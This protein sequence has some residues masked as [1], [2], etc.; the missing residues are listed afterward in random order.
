MVSTPERS[1]VPDNVSHADLL[2]LLNDPNSA[3]PDVNEILTK[4]LATLSPDKQREI[5]KGI[6]FKAEETQLEFPRHD[7]I[8]ADEKLPGFT[9]VKDNSEAESQTPST[10][11][12]PEKSNGTSPTYELNEHGYIPR[13][14]GHFVN[15]CTPLAK[16]LVEQGNLANNPKLRNE[17]RD[18]MYGFQSDIPAKQVKKHL[19]NRIN[20]MRDASPETLSKVFLRLR[21]LANNY[22]IQPVEASPV[23]N[24]RYSK[25]NTDSQFRND[26]RYSDYMNQAIRFIHQIDDKGGLSKSNI[27]IQV[28]Q[29]IPE[30]NPEIGERFI[31]RHL[32][33]KLK[34]AAE[35]LPADREQTL[36]RKLEKIHSE[37]PDDVVVIKKSSGSYVPINQQSISKE[38]AQGIQLIETISE[39][40]GLKLS[41]TV[42]ALCSIIPKTDS[43]S[44]PRT[45][46]RHLIS[47]L[48]EAGAE[49]PPAEH[50]T[51]LT[52]LEAVL[53][54]V[55][56]IPGRPAKIS[57]LENKPLSVE[58]ISAL[59]TIEAMK[60]KGCFDDKNVLG[61][62][63]EVIP[64]VN[65][66][67]HRRGLKG[68]FDKLLKLANYLPEDQQAGIARNLKKILEQA[69]ENQIPTPSVRVKSTTSVI[70]K[71]SSAN[72]PTQLFNS[73]SDIIIE[74]DRKAGLSNKA[75]VAELCQ[76]I[77]G[78]IPETNVKAIKRHI[79][80]K[81]RLALTSEP[82]TFQQSLLAKLKSVDE[83]VVVVDKKTRT[84][85]RKILPNKNIELATA[86][87]NRIAEEVGL[88][89]AEIRAKICAIIPDTNPK[90]IA[91]L[92][93]KHLIAKVKIALTIRPASEQLSIIEKLQDLQANAATFNDS[94][95]TETTPR[96]SRPARPTLEKTPRVLQTKDSIRSKKTPDVTAAP[97]KVTKPERV[98]RPPVSHVVL[99]AD[100]GVDL[101]LG[102]S[103]LGNAFQTLK[104][105]PGVIPPIPKELT[106][107]LLSSP[108]PFFPTMRI[109][110]THVL[111][112]IPATLNQKPLSITQ[113]TNLIRP[114]MS[115][116]YREGKV[117]NNFPFEKLAFLNET[118]TES[119]WALIPMYAPKDPNFENYEIASARELFIT[120]AI[121]LKFA[122]RQ[123]FGGKVACTSTQVTDSKYPIITVGSNEKKLNVNFTNLPSL[124]MSSFSYLGWGLKRIL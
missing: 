3:L 44:D 6:I 1:S 113:A 71:V 41:A 103:F 33:A 64:N 100:M 51:F 28:C 14:S 83:Q 43:S 56:E 2:S 70:T 32:I 117:L 76:L 123:I 98:V 40:G 118:K 66:D 65:R 46:K 27:R 16:V 114:A 35:I 19:A 5:L 77:P 110:D 73:A 75:T 91:M 80:A 72:F 37:I 111:S 124:N 9:V 116:G 55:P 78:T 47:K 54:T 22:E 105:Y 60:D 108:C 39:R 20:F 62:I 90:I 49:T 17:L 23:I 34:R 8:L 59:E 96:I 92:L 13:I 112:L 15:W 122:D 121:M 48:R 79:I 50:Q 25:V 38:I 26:V 10:N 42:M 57:K 45:I 85:T 84:I 97:V 82:E 87:I 61:L 69:P 18:L 109:L 68:H 52:K 4:V 101:A 119:Y 81:L 11:S 95:K 36:F 107:E 89:K 106:L 99:T 31:K 115:Y 24:P 58:I 94:S 67:T 30:A 7:S 104:L 29:A 12:F 88:N 120:A 21:E 86:L 63:A 53:I 102:M 74:I 93:K